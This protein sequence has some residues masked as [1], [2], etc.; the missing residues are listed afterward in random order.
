[1]L[2]GRDMGKIKIVVDTNIFISAFLGSK[3]ARFLLKDIINDEYILIMSSEQLLEIKEVLNRPKF[4]KYI[5][6][7][8]IDE[9]V[10]LISLKAI[11]PAIYD[12]ITDCRDE[13]DNMILEEAVYGN[14][15][16]IITGDDDLLILNPYRWIKIVM[17]RDFLNEIYDL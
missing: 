11:M 17:L 2:E 5:S 3:K 15:N 10:E 14:A 13:K 9:L 7:A 16:Y 8:E 1:M 6:K 12:K 4:E